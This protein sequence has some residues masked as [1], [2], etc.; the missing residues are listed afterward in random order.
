MAPPKAVLFDIGGVVS[1]FQA[2]VNYEKENNIPDGWVNF[3]ISRSAPDGHWHRLERGEIEIGKDFFTGFGHDLSDRAGWKDFCNRKPKAGQK[4]LKDVANP[5]QLGDP[6]SLKAETADSEPTDQDRG[7]SS[8]SSHNRSSPSQ[9][10]SHASPRKTLKDLAR[11]NP[12]QLGDPVSLKAET[13][14]SSPTPDDRGAHRPPTTPAS[15]PSSSTTPTPPLPTINAE[16]LFWAMMS[17]SRTPDPHIYPYVTYL[18]SLTPRP[19]LL[20]ALSNT[21]TFPPAHPFNVPTSLSSTLRRLFDVFVASAEVG[22]RK[23]HREIYELALREMDRWDRERGGAGVRAA[24]VLFLDD[25]GE[26]LRTGREVGFRTLR[27][28]LGASGEARRELERILGV[29]MEGEVKA[30]L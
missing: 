30:K 17:I 21:I 8:T 10:P 29:R 20:A 9:P 28:R 14:N 27:V 16:T 24:D 5:S 22:L 23:P 18:A 19:F 4:R 12:S 25:I 26:N 7:A 3:A 1:P 15:S 13:A 11:A 2:I 6:T